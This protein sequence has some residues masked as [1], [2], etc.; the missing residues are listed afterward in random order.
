MEFEKTASL[1]QAN[2]HASHANRHGRFKSSHFFI[3]VY[4]N[5]TFSLVYCYNFQKNSVYSSK[6]FPV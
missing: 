6:L 3:S 4:F 5:F 2:C 1:K